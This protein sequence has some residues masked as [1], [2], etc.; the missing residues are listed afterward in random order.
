MRYAGLLLL[1]LLTG[2]ATAR[3]N[4]IEVPI[5]K[6]ESRKSSTAENIEAGGRVLGGAWDRLKGAKDAN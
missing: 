3:D 2:C 5:V 4:K 1:G 6:I